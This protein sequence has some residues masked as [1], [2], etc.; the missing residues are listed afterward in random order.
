[1]IYP[2]DGE[3]FKAQQRKSDILIFF[4]HFFQGHKKALK[5]HIELVNE[6]GFDACF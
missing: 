5:R 6:L 4:V 3:L 2:D 1:M